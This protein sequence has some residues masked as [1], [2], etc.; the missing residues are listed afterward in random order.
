MLFCPFCFCCGW[1]VCCAA[2]SLLFSRWFSGLLARARANPSHKML[3]FTVF[4][5]FCASGLACELLFLGWGL[6]RARARATPCQPSGSVLWH[7]LGL[8]WA[9]PNQPY[10]STGY[11]SHTKDMTWHG[12]ISKRHSRLEAAGPEKYVVHPICG[13]LLRST[14]NG[15]LWLWDA[16]ATC[17]VASLRV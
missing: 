8:G 14:H 16:G 12:I 10:H 17:R 4:C 5:C 11:V 6:W 2:R 13:T 15:L 1:L 7:H 3:L 9:T